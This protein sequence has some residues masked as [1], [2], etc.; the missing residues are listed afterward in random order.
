M[1]LIKSRKWRNA[2]VEDWCLWVTNFMKSWTHNKIFLSLFCTKVKQRMFPRSKICI[3]R[4]ESG[5]KVLRKFLSSYTLLEIC[6]QPFNIM[7]ILNILLCLISCH[8]YV[9]KAVTSTLKP[10]WDSQTSKIHVRSVFLSTK[11]FST[12][13]LIVCHPSMFLNVQ[14]KPLL[15]QCV[16]KT[17]ANSIEAFSLSLMLCIPCQAVFAV[18]HM[19]FF[20][21][22]KISGKQLH[23]RER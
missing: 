15:Y 14:M 6:A 1:L 5:G 2:F 18:V 7:S 3:Y 19:F 10:F 4:S 23:V 8:E 13:N 12:L 20:S 9:V 11:A 17:R 21:I 16:S 22:L